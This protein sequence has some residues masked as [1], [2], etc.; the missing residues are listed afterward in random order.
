LERAG[1][2]QA[3]L[4]E[5]LKAVREATFWLARRA[6]GGLRN[7]AVNSAHRLRASMRRWAER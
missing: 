4:D 1:I 5:D 6:A 7:A 3:Q 2:T